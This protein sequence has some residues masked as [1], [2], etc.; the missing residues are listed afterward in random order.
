LSQS[1]R[2]SQSDQRLI[3]VLCQLE[4]FLGRLELSELLSRDSVLIREKA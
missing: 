3:E 4:L 1:D 2:L